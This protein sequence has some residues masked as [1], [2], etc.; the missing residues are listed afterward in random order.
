MQTEPVE[1]RIVI[2][3][4][5][6]LVLGRHDSGAEN[7]ERSDRSPHLVI[8][9]VRDIGRACNVD[10]VDP[11]I[12][13]L[14]NGG[15]KAGTAVTREDE[16]LVIVKSKKFALGGDARLIAGIF[17]QGQ[18]YNIFSNQLRRIMAQIIG[19]KPRIATCRVDT[20]GSRSW[21]RALCRSTNSVLRSGLMASPS[22]PWLF[23]RPARGLPGLGL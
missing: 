10:Q 6:A 4:E 9:G 5:K 13:R 16:K 15:R 7:A 17:V 1:L 11:A 2:D 12:C 22:N 18:L 20:G 14:G 8:V 21:I 19:E 23:C 3:V